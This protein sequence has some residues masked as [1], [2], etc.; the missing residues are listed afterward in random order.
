MSFGVLA[1]QEK[2]HVS[3]MKYP[4]SSAS[5]GPVVQRD[6]GDVR[7]HLS[8][9]LRSSKQK[10]DYIGQMALKILALIWMP[11]VAMHPRCNA[12]LT[13]AALH[14]GVLFFTCGVENTRVSLHGRKFLLISVSLH[15]CACSQC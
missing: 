5:H 2:Q 4:V 7:T 11:Q 12:I 6:E 13:A 9:P 10:H 1:T 3:K 8:A 15:P 14:V